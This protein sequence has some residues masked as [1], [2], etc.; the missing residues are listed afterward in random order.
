MDYFED[1]PYGLNYDDILTS[2][3]SG[4]EADFHQ[5]D[6]GDGEDWEDKAVRWASQPYPPLS[7]LWWGDLCSFAQ[8]ILLQVLPNM[9]FS[10][11]L[12]LLW[13]ISFLLL[14]RCPPQRDEG[15]PPHSKRQRKNCGRVKCC[16]AIS[17]SPATPSVGP[18]LP[19]CLP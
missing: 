3:M 9:L 13:R 2:M 19:G 4:E 14:T 18:K 17:R 11:T 8:N 12:C 7:S 1:N 16:S 5:F 15:N 10:L 6:Y